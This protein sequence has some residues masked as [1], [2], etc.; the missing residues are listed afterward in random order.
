MHPSKKWLF[1]QP[2]KKKEFL[3]IAATQY[4]FEKMQ[5]CTIA[6]DFVRGSGTSQNHLNNKTCQPWN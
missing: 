1:W 2:L 6:K 4:P 5:A 3:E